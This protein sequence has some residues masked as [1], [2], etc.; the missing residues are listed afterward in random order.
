M[1]AAET[2]VAGRVATLAGDEGYGWVEAIA[3]AGGQVLAAGSRTEVDGFAGP[4][5][6]RLVLGP[7]EVALPG[8]TDAH[9]HLADAAVAADRVDLSG[10]DALADGLARVGAAAAR[11][12]DPEVWLEGG[13]W[14][15]NRWGRWPTADDLDAAAPGRRVALWAHD[16]HALLVSRR[17]LAEAGVDETTPDPPGGSIRRG[18]AG[19]PTG[20]LHEHASRLVTVRIPPPDDDR[21]DRAIERWA[22]E[23]LALGIVAVHDMGPLAPDPDLAGGFAAV[24]R[25][26]ASGRLPIRVHAGLREES[27]DAAIGRG[28]RTGEPIRPGQGR[29]RVG[30]WKRFADGSLGSRTAYVREPYL[31]ADPGAAER[32]GAALLEPGDLGPAIRRAAEGGIATA[33]HAIGDAAVDLAIASFEAADPPSLAAQPRIEHAQLVADD[34]LPRLRAAGI[35]LSMQ[36]V[37]ARTD[38]PSLGPAWGDRARALGYRWRSVVDAGIRLAFGSDTPVE[39]VDPWPGLAAAIDRS[40]G[41]LGPSADWLDPAEALTLPSALRAACVAPALIAGEPYRGRLVARQ[42]ADLVVVALPRGSRLDD[43]AIVA[44]L[45][46]RLVLID[47]SVAWEA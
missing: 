35:A 16:H 18:D 47:G 8:L 12:P 15:P 45:R 38:G 34:Q 19:R 6:R 1:T 33:V 27:L 37:H 11:Q 31:D 39:S 23:L 41:T 17:A 14:D 36:P 32:R 40:A 24:A 28:H 7:D 29:A 9:V 20:V 4:E 26:D 25:L 30:W 44:T 22:G 46:P 43:P 21:L 10:C 2:I 3:L 42:R 13:G 5:T